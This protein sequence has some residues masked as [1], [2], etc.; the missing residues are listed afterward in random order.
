[1]AVL[2]LTLLSLPRPRGWLD[3]GVELPAVAWLLIR[4]QGLGNWRGKN[5]LC[6]LPAPAQYKSACSSGVRRRC[7]SR[8]VHPAL[9]PTGGRWRAVQGQG[10]RSHAM[11]I[12]TGVTWFMCPS[13]L[14]AWGSRAPATPHAIANDEQETN[15]NGKQ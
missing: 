8:S 6:T 1:M 2:L 13:P 11:G 5:T 7:S 12:S 10:T 14:C 4:E 3:L 15:L 9:A